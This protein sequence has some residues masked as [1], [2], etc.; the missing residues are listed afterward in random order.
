M[1]KFRLFSIL[2]TLFACFIALS[3]WSQTKPIAYVLKVNGA[4]SPATQDYLVRGIEQANTENARLVIIELDTPGGLDKSMRGIIKAII[5][6]KIPI[7]TYVSPA[8]ARAASAGTYIL[9]ASHVAAMAPGTNLGAATPVSLTGGD[10][11]KP[12]GDDKKPA[13]KQPSDM[14]KKV[15]NDAIAYIKSLAQLRNRNADWAVKAVDEAAS[16]PAKEALQLKVIDII[17]P[18]IESLLRQANGRQV[19]VD[20]KIEKIQSQDLTLKRIIP[21]WKNKVLTVITDPS[22]AYI[23]LLIG[24]YGLF[25]EFFKPGF[26][27][28]GVAGAICLLLALY[29]L[30]LL[31][32]NYAGLA[33][34][35]LG[36]IFMVAEAF[37]PSFG[38]LGF[39][40]VIAF[41]LGSFLLLDTQS[42][43]YQ[44]NWWLILLMAGINALF[45]MV[46]IGLIIKNRKAKV[47]SGKEALINMQGTVVENFEQEGWVWVR[48][49]RWKAKTTQPLKKGQK[50][51]VNAVNGLQLDISPVEDK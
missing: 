34:I 16:I 1:T 10:K 47:V 23:L 26:I 45:F 28:P 20:G 4:I 49:E 51:K 41:V 37:L 15:R 22:I 43:L 8:G 24:V 30:Q 17:A 3:A 29:A 25:F 7:L 2:I 38:A 11:A 40:G 19:N 13:K 50:V 33:L 32:I 21:D 46:I 27:V 35:L 48:G 42:T 14:Q 5:A 36:I 31:P 39:G 12:P 6:S 18:N 44:I 9:Y